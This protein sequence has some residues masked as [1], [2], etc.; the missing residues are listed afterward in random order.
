MDDTDGMLSGGH[1]GGD[2]GL[3][4]D[5]VAALLAEDPSLLSSSPDISLESHLMAF[6]AEKS[7]LDD[8]RTVSI[9]L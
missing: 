5:F 3:M 7:R 2:A 6:A 1:L 4:H 8:G 9:Q